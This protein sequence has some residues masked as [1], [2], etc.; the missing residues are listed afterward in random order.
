MPGGLHANFHSSP[1]F[2]VHDF[3]SPSS[4]HL[5]RQLQEVFREHLLKARFCA[6]PR[7]RS[8]DSDMTPV[9]GELRARPEACWVNNY[10]SRIKH[11]ELKEGRHQIGWGLRLELVE[12]LGKGPLLR[13]ELG[14]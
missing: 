1:P 5:S 2:Y 12:G 14:K 6:R 8:C 3:Q 11:S 7:G 13:F 9:L 4:F 10:G